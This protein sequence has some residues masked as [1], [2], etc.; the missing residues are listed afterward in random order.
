MGTDKP[1]TA[2]EAIEA[3]AVECEETG[4]SR[5]TISSVARLVLECADPPTYLDGL[6]AARDAVSFMVGGGLV[7]SP[8]V[9]DE[10]LVSV[11]KQCL[12]ASLKSIDKL[13]A[14][15]EREANHANT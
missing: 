15:A 5:E 2:R 4:A 6:R 10:T 12:T 9:P 8:E 14:D 7:F 13:I 11:I 3:A 1:T